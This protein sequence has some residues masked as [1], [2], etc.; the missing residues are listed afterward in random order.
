[1]FNISSKKIPRSVLK[2]VLSVEIKARDL[3][4]NTARTF[5]IGNFRH[6]AIFFIK[7]FFITASD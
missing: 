2:G 5:F 3:N 4:L 6:K 7:D 1:M